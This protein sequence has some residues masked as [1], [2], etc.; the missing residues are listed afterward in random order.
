MDIDAVQE[1][2]LIRKRIP[3]KQ[4]VEF[5]QIIGKMVD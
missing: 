3:Q 5:T 1:S 2:F 4:E